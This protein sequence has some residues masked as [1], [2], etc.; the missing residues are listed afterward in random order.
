MVRR[1]VAGPRYIA[2]NYCLFS[3]P[4][5]NTFLHRRSPGTNYIEDQRL[6]VYLPHLLTAYL[7]MSQQH[8]EWIFSESLS[9]VR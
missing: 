4:T 2:L 7:L 6:D 8:Y 5:C 3:C 9:V 1:D